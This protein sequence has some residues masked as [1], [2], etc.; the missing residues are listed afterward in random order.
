[1]AI[2]INRL[3]PSHN[4]KISS[5]SDNKSS[6]KSSASPAASTSAATPSDKVEVSEQAKKLQDIQVSLNAQP[7]INS[8]KV[9]EIKQAIAEGRYHVDPEKLASNI[10]KLEQQLDG[11]ID[12]D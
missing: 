4:G 12:E 2:D 3:T 1:M 5:A 9:A 11:L 10:A 7:E 8:A 6:A